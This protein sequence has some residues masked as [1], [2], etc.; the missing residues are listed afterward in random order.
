MALASRSL[1]P[2][3]GASRAAL[4]QTSKCWSGQVCMVREIC[5]IAVLPGRWPAGHITADSAHMSIAW[6][7]GMASSRAI[8]DTACAGVSALAVFL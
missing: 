8:H 3:H 7:Q 6:S 1:K 4:V 5:G 2:V